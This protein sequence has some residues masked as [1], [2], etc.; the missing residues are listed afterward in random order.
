MAVT[1]YTQ[2]IHTE[3]DTCFLAESPVESFTFQA[4]LSEERCAQVFRM[5]DDVCRLGNRAL[6]I[7]KPRVDDLKEIVMYDYLIE[8][9]KENQAAAEASAA[10]TPDHFIAWN[11]KKEAS[12]QVFLYFQMN[13]ISP[14]ALIDLGYSLGREYGNPREAFIRSRCL[15]LW[16]RIARAILDETDTVEID[17]PDQSPPELETADFRDG[18]QIGLEEESLRIGITGIPPFGVIPADDKQQAAYDALVGFLKDPAGF[19]AAVEKYVD[20]GELDDIFYP[21]RCAVICKQ[22]EGQKRLYIKFTICF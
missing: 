1:W 19:T 2:K 15:T 18:L 8:M 10:N 9:V 14:E 20:T 5:A 4:D 21:I 7:L 16:P 6:A 13:G 17:S 11:R 12:E 3:Q 22:D